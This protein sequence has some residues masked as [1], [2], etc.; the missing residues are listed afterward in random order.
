MRAALEFYADLE[1]YQRLKLRNSYGKEQPPRLNTG[2]SDVDE[3]AGK[4]A[5]NALSPYAGQKVLDVVRVA[6][7]VKKVEEEMSQKAN[8]VAWDV[9]HP[10]FNT[11]DALGW[12]P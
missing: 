3:D 6:F 10:L 12:K 8:G 5:L 7:E 9:L 1:S 2:K 11:L 4:R